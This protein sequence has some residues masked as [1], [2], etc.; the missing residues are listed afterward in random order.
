MLIA[1]SAVDGRTPTCF[2]PPYGST[3]S[4]SRATAT[5]LGLRVVLWDLDPQDWRTP[6]A[7]TIADYV[8]LHARPGSVVLLHDGGGDRSQTVTAVQETVNTLIRLGYNLAA[9]P[10]C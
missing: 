4:Q 3:D 5:S 10:G 9:I 1:V 6:G 2:L 8:I 7:A